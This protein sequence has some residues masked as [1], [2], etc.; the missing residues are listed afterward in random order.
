MNDIAPREDPL[1]RS[2]RT[3]SVEADI[4]IR[5]S[6]LPMGEQKYRSHSYEKIMAGSMG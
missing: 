2:S 3:I 5:C 4:N 6:S 1:V